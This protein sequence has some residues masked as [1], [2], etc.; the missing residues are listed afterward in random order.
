MLTPVFIKHGE[1]PAEQHLLSQCM[2]LCHVGVQSTSDLHNAS[3]LLELS[4]MDLNQLKET[5]LKPRLIGIIRV[6]PNFDHPLQSTSNTPSISQ[7]LAGHHLIT[8]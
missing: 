5:C 2:F 6:K 3:V 1:N 8:S 4:A 7:H